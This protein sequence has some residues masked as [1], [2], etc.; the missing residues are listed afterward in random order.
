MRVLALTWTPEG[1]LQVNSSQTHNLIEKAY[2][3]G[4]L[5]EAERKRIKRKVKRI[6][7]QLGEFRDA[8]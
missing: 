4:E 3:R 8:A 2:R 5:S 1:G 6:T 7:K